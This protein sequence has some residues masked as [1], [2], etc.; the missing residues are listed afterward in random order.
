MEQIVWKPIKSWEGVYQISNTGVVK[1]MQN[2]VFGGH[3]KKQRIN[4]KER[5]RTHSYIQ[6][7]YCVIHLCKRP[8]IKTCLVHRL[9]AMHFIPNPE[10]KPEVNHLDGN[11][12]NNNYLNLE[13][14]TE[15]ENV[16]HAAALGLR[17]NGKIKRDTIPEKIVLEI[18]NSECSLSVLA[19]KY[20]LPKLT[21]QSIK[22]GKRYGRITKK[23]Y[24]GKTR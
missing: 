21:I 19:K 5:L 1:T 8:I 24:F 4:V 23:Q 6:D 3:R 11:K 10:N 15:K 14:S 20:S 12:L 7:G 9:V 22:S 2:I 13:W 16:N 18:F 17:N